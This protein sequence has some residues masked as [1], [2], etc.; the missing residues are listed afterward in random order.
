[1]AQL[2]GDQRGSGD[3]SEEDGSGGEEGL[4][5]RFEP[6]KGDLPPELQE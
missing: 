6:L 1:M 3:G 4:R 2:Y 5:V